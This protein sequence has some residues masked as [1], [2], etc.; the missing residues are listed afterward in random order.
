[1]KERP[2]T[3]T[4]EEVLAILDN[5]K[6]QTRRPQGLDDVNNYPGKLSGSCSLG[7]DLGYQG[8][9]KSNYYIKNKKG[10]AKNNGLV[11]MFV[12]ESK[13]EKEINP[14]P[15]KCPFGAA[16]DRLWVRETWAKLLAPDGTSA[17]QSV[18]VYKADNPQGLLVPQKWCSPIFMPRWASRI[19]LEIINVRAEKLQDI[20]Y[21]DAIA[22]GILQN[23]SWWT[24][25][26]NNFR[27]PCDA[28]HFLWDSINGKKHPWDNN[29]WVW[30]IDFERIN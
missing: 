7:G 18:V 13:D 27:N 19:T 20:N 2:I 24:V 9:A 12:G 5:R 21:A 15:V 8:L 23:Y 30:V 17:R 11:H 14:I 4:A 6:S 26:E 10:Y 3:F 22:E 16:G 28:F 25:K 29:D 1:M